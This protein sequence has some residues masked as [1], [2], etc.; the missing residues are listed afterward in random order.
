VKTSTW[1]NQAAPANKNDRA[2]KYYR[3]E[4]VYLALN[5]AYLAREL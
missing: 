1:P 5:S 4:Q 2:I 3:G